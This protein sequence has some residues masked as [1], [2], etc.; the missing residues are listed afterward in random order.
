MSGGA[1]IAVGARLVMTGAGSCGCRT[2][3]TVLKV[4]PTSLAVTTSPRAC[5]GPTRIVATEAAVWVACT[6]DNTEV[7]VDPLSLAVAVTPDAVWV[8]SFSDN[9]VRRLSS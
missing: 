4:D 7:K 2:T 8:S 1:D 6:L 3:G 5:G 9:T